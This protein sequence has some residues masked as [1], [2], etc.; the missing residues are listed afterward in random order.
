MNKEELKFIENLS[1]KKEKTQVEEEIAILHE[2]RLKLKY[3]DLYFIDYFRA[4]QIDGRTF[5]IMIR[6]N[7]CEC[8]QY[9]RHIHVWINGTHFCW[10]D[11]LDQALEEVVK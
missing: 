9:D 2:L 8:Y 10:K 7:N 5:P 11:A 4:L 6:I 3:G 1:T